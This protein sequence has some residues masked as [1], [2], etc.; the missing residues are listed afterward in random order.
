M[1]TFITHIVEPRRVLIRWQ[2]GFEEE[3]WHRTNWIVGE[4]Q[5]NETSVDLLYYIDSVETAR[6]MELGFTGYPGFPLQAQRH[7][8]VLWRLE[9][10]LPSRHRRDYSD[11]LQF[12]YIDPNT[13]PSTLS[14]IAYT[15]ARLPSDGFSFIHPFDDVEPPCELLTEVAGV[16][17]Y[18]EWGNSEID[19]DSTVDL[20]PEPENEYDS[21]AIRVEHHNRLVGY[22]TRGHTTPIK[23]WLERS[24]VRATI[25]RL[26]GEESRP[27]IYLFVEVR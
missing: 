19:L 11:Y 5:R 22:I 4:L 6:A 21:E 10:R 24:S 1:N 15:G 16:R 14:V 7:E 12:F 17:H 26:I 2:S 27:R 25:A 20:V 18:N 8:D 23:R 3:N 9:R 13:N